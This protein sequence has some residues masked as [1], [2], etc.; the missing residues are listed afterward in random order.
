MDKEPVLEHLKISCGE[1]SWFFKASMCLY[2]RNFLLLF[3]LSVLPGC[4]LNA[5]IQDMSPTSSTSP[6]SSLF[7]K[8]TGA[9][10]VAGSSQYEHTLLRNY[11]NISS[12]GSI[13]K[14]I[15]SITPRGYKAFSSVQG[16]LISSKAANP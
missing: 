8:V 1:N 3:S 5:S 9:E 16:T 10:F 7:D 15:Q 2:F 4:Y 13:S 12:A 11:R 6:S 14:E